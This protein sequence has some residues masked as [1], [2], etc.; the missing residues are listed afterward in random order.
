MSQNPALLTVAV[1]SP[2]SSSKQEIVFLEEPQKVFDGNQAVR[3][4][5]AGGFV[6]RR[7][8][9]SDYLP[10]ERCDLPLISFVQ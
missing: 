2:V 1:S 8:A 5:R 4:D 10:R 9:F 6:L 7:K 3:E